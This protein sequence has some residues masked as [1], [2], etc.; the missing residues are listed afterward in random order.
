MDP[1]R[2]YA[3]AIA[4]WQLGGR[5][6][7]GSTGGLRSDLDLKFGTILVGQGEIR[8]ITQLSTSERYLIASAVC[9]RDAL[10]PIRRCVVTFTRACSNTAFT[11]RRAG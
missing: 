6:C 4:A 1:A 3:P 5:P 9:P 10:P 7:C 11:R 8:P 2:V